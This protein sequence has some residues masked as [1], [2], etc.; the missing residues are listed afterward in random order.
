MWASKRRLREERDDLRAQLD[1]M[2]ERAE[3]AERNVETEQFARN[4][5]ARQ[6]AEADAANRRLHGRNVR[7]TEQLERAHE[8]AQDGALDE[9]GHRLDRALRA[10]ARYRAE[11]AEDRAAV[12]NAHQQLKEKDAELARA[13]VFGR[14]NLLRRLDLAERARR[15]LAEQLATVQ[16]ANDAMCR[17][18]ISIAGTLT[19]P[20]ADAEKPDE[21]AW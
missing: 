18:R 19:V 4:T 10:C 5:M 11:G 6:F 7:L 17:E 1:R 9:M 8:A 3:T 14:A 2:R 15:S 12:M 16:A 20:A 21:V 13:R